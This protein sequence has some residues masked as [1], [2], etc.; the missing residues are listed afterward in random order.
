M[1]Y[2][3]VIVIIICSVANV[4]MHLYWIIKPNIIYNFIAIMCFSISY[5]C[6]VHDV[7]FYIGILVPFIVIYLFNWGIFIIIMIQ[8]MK[9]NCRS[10]FKESYSSNQKMSPKQQ[11]SIALTLSLLFGLGWGIGLLA[12]HTLYPVTAVRDTFAALFILL[13][14]FQGLFIFIMHCVRSREVRREWKRWAYKAVGKDFS[15]T[16]TNSSVSQFSRRAM[17]RQSSMATETSY[18]DRSATLRHNVT[19][20]QNNSFDFGVVYQ[21]QDK[22]LAAIEKQLEAKEYTF[23]MPLDDDMSSYPVPAGISHMVTS[24]LWTSNSSHSLATIDSGCCR[25]CDNPMYNNELG[26]YQTTYGSG[27]LQHSSSDTISRPDSIYCTNV[28][29]PLLDSEGSG[30]FHDEDI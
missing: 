30:V 26:S 10:K 22:T 17:K 14:G 27:Q 24:D 19:K 16:A 13:T 2:Y 7:P 21:D 1:K 12:T 18:I 11:F 29:N 23:S 20:M 9:K 3:I 5:S 4:S 15:T 6:R 28:P 8:L 25:N